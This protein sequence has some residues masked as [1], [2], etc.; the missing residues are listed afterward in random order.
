MARTPSWENAVTDYLERIDKKVDRYNET[1]QISLN[2][3]ISEYHKMVREMTEKITEV[4]T[5]VKIYA[6]IAGAVGA[7]IG[8]IVGRLIV[9]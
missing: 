1:A 4:R 9:K 2:T 5:Q 8:G 3:H 6:A 7:A